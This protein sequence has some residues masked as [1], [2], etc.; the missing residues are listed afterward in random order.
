MNNAA[1]VSRY[2]SFVHISGVY[3]INVSI[4]TSDVS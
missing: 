2:G 4:R 3:M 1:F